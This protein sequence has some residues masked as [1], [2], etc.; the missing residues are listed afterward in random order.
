MSRN[1]LIPVVDSQ[2]IE[3]IE[4]KKNAQVKVF[5]ALCVSLMYGSDVNYFV[6]VGDLWEGLQSRATS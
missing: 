1:K 3:L 2:R 5:E 6:M 4:I